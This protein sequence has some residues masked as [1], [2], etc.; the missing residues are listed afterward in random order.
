MSRRNSEISCCL[1]RSHGLCDRA[2]LCTRV[3]RC[4]ARAHRCD[5]RLP[6]WSLRQAAPGHPRV[7][8]REKTAKGLARKP[9]CTRRKAATEPLC[10]HVWRR[11]TPGHTGVIHGCHRATSGKP[12]PGHP[13]VSRRNSE[14]SCCLSR[15]H[16]LC[17]RAT[18]CTRVARCDARAHR[19]DTRLPTWSLRQAAPGHPRVSGREKTAKGHARKPMCTRRKAA[20]EPL[21]AHVWRRVTPGH[22][23]VIHGCHR[24]TSGKT[25]R[26]PAG[27]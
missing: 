23:G 10:A 13:R 9:M 15:S 1:S 22:T 26:P 14:I 25:P 21:C 27:V 4:D 24:A 18:L 7:S 12:P 11:V 16:G 6:T 5:T 8:G 2:T 19:C 20:T 17:D 3:A